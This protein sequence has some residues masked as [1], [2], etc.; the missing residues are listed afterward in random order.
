MGKWRKRS[1]KLNVNKEEIMR[2]TGVVRRVDELGRIVIP[3]ELRRTMDIKEKDPLE[4]FTEDETIVLRKFR[5]N[6]ACMI[7]GN[8]SSDNISLFDG[9]LVISPEIAKILVRELKEFDM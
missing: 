2:A 4:I 1:R 8:V 9:K 7:T 5:S 3:K 6:M